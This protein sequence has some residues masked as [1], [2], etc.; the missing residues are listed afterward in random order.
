MYARADGGKYA[1]IIAINV[2]FYNQ[3]EIGI[4]ILMIDRHG[5]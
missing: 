1:D 4:C 2:S 5:L 3:Y